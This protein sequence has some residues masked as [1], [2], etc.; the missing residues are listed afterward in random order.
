MPSEKPSSFNVICD[1]SFSKILNTTRSPNDDG[2]VDTLKS[3][4]LFPMEIVI[5]PSCGILLSDI[6]NLDIILI[7]EISI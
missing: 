2:N 5:R 6:S 7:L 4:L 3:T 1:L